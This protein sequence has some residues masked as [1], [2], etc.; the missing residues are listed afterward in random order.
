M[1]CCLAWL[2]V[3]AIFRLSA[4]KHES[5]TDRERLRRIVSALGMF[6]R[7]VH[8]RAVSVE[9][10]RDVDLFHLGR[11]EVFESVLVTS[12]KHAK[13]VGLPSEDVAQFLNG[14]APILQQE[15]CR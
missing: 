9:V 11:R 7:S 12:Y 3:V 13:V 1:K 8:R 2:W 4:I 5:S 15:P 10:Q 14:H 6:V